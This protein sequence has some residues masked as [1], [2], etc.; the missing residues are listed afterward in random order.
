MVPGGLSP[1]PSRWGWGAWQEEDRPGAGAVAG[2]LHIYL[3]EG[4][5]KKN[6]GL[7]WAFEA[8]KPSP[9]PQFL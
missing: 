6:L 9:V 3:Q 4:G 7:A 2:C 8:S 5:G 1:G